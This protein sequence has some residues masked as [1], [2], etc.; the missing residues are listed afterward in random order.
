LFSL[1]GPK[2]RTVA[3]I[4]LPG[5]GKTVFLA[6]MFWDSFFT[7]AETFREGGS[8][9]AV[10]AVNAKADD[11]FYGNAKLLHERVLP[12][13]NPRSGEPQPAVLEFLGVPS[14][15][16]RKRSRIWLT[17]Y[18]VAGE[19]FASDAAAEADAAYLDEADDLV[20]LFDPTQPDFSALT[21]ARLVD[22]I[23]RVI[24]G[25]EEKNFIIALS[26]MDELR[27]TDEWAG[28]IGEYW[29]GHAPTV[30][31][32]DEYL[33]EMESLSDRFREWWT[34][35]ER[36]A[37]NLIASLPPGTRFCGVSSLGHQPVKDERGALRL[38]RKP[39]PFRVRDPL[40][41]IFRAA[42]VI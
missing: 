13:A 15:R 10:R 12:P 37:H 31:G 23:H 39:E 18:D 26:K 35:P 32:L 19:V 40:F 4:G 2:R 20:F 27:E 33:A 7:L 14:S 36:G 29:P 25:S 30:S 24:P 1:F 42:G 28:T 6:G 17:F 3:T 38:T 16:S 5:H 21:A 9:Y 8:H 11:V 34:F 22:R 41:W